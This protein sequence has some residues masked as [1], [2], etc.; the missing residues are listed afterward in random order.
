M[1]FLHCRS[2]RV[3]IE[4]AC[5][6]DVP[7]L[8]SGLKSCNTVYNVNIYF[9]GTIL[10]ESVLVTTAVQMRSKRDFVFDEVVKRRGP[11]ETVNVVQGLELH[12]GLLN[13]QE[14]A[15]VVGAIESWVE[16]GRAVSHRLS[17]ALSNFKFDSC[18]I[19]RAG[20]RLTDSC[21]GILHFSHVRLHARHCKLV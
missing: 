15:R 12:K 3:F 21:A 7:C 19:W 4:G 17:S 9:V 18:L 11:P 6:Q 16:A 20:C 10:S 8:L 5:L 2:P 14:Q 1:L 13:A